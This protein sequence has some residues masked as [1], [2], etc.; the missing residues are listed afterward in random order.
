MRGFTKTTVTDYK[1]MWVRTDFTTYSKE[2]EKIRND[3]G[4]R[5]LSCFKCD[6][7]FKYGDII[8]LACFVN[9]GNETLC[10]KCA[11]ELAEIE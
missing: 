3:V 6:K 5:M 11:S 1:P 7:K 2:Y 9:H 4:G 10:S 8:G